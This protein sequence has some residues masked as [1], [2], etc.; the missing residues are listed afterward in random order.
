MTRFFMI[1]ALALSMITVQMPASATNICD[2]NPEAC[3]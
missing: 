1:A 2:R 3:E